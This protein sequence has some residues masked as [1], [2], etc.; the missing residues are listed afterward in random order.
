MV[1]R[2]PR[3]ERV[4][5]KNLQVLICVSKTWCFVG[6]SGRI[7]QG[8]SRTSRASRVAWDFLRRGGKSSSKESIEYPVCSR[9]CCIEG[10][11]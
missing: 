4:E 8:S 11:E 9:I 5:G 6:S 1:E 7:Y 3:R 2:R 10:S